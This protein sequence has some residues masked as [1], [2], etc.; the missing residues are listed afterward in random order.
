M[1]YSKDH[2]IIKI[3][4]DIIEQKLKRKSRFLRSRWFSS[5]RKREYAVLIGVQILLFSAIY[6]FNNFHP[7]LLE[8]RYKRME[9]VPGRVLLFFLF[10]MLLFQVVFLIYIAYLYLKYK[11]TPSV[12]DDRL[13]VCTVIVPAYNEGEL[14]YHTLKSIASSDYPCDKL[15]LM[16]VDDG[17]TDQTWQ[18]IIKAK[19]ELGDILKVYQ[20]PKNKGKR[21]ALHKGFTDGKGEVFV[22]IDSDS[23]IEKDTLRN[24]VSP[25]IVNQNC[26]AV[27]G[28]VKVLNKNRGMIPRMLNVS[29]VFSFEFIRAAQST[30]GFVLCT[31]GALSA[32]RREA[33][34][35]CLDKWIHQK[36]MGNFATIGEDRAM[37]NFILQQGYDVTFQRNANV[38][39]NTPVTFKNLHKMFTR[40]GRSNVRETLMMN[41]FI[42]KKF[43]KKRTVYGEVFIFFNQWVKLILAYPLLV[44]MI[45]FLLTHPLL[46]L[47]S[48]LTS[49]FVFS[50][51]QML[52]FTKKYNFGDSL[53]AYPYSVFYLGALFWISPYAIVTVKN[54]GWLTR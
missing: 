23:I 46:Y 13:P 15:E 33:V 11:E 18:W 8:L 41:K 28:N 5:L 54:G 25:F 12:S 43:R 10:S 50:S 7:Y 26:G 27:A 9:T 21:H 44:L 51:I 4:H 42:F 48:A 45:Y 3:S 24:L 32:Y 49:A 29:F 19:N 35:H 30:L 39:T 38:L 52:F 1:T 53:W 40:W 36:F 47:S 14:V 31:P 34:A 37:T 17:S 6:I 22:T 16:A 20:Q 2:S